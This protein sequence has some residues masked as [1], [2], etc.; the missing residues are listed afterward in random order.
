MVVIMIKVVLK[1]VG[2]QGDGQGGS[3][4]QGGLNCSFRGN[5]CLH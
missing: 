3:G 2:C 1:V 4:G 5:C